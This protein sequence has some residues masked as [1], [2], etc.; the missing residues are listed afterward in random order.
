MSKYYSDVFKFINAL[1]TLSAINLPFVSDNYKL[2]FAEVWQSYTFFQKILRLSSILLIVY[3][4]GFFSE[5]SNNT[6]V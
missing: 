6:A 3:F 4:S 5:L 2:D 1:L